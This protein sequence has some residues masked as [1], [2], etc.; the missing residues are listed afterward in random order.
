M[1]LV[2]TTESRRNI[3]DLASLI[4]G[5][6][7]FHPWDALN[8]AA[9]H[10]IAARSRRRPL[11]FTAETGC[12]GSTIL[13]SHLSQRHTAFALEGA[14]LTVSELKR[15]D[16]L[17]ADRV[18]FIEGET[19]LTLP[20]YQFLSKLDLLLL[21]GPHAYPLPQI[22]F[23][24]LFPHLKTGG[25]LVLDDLQIPSVYEL[26]KFVKSSSEVVLEEVVGRTAFFRRTQPG[27]HVVGNPDG[28]WLQQMNRSLVWR[29]SWRDRLR[30]LF[31]PRAKN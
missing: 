4:A 27:R 28:W 16:D 31:R 12:G 21:D 2:V 25:W 17:L 29:Y 24:Y 10:G 13:L 15:R 11:E 26:F 3:R 20:V 23:A 22:E 5:A 14:D 30:K 1:G 9:L 19:R 7:S 6:I 18:E 8:P